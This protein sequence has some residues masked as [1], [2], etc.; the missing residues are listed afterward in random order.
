MHTPLAGT[1]MAQPGYRHP[2]LLPVAT[3][4]W[5]GLQRRPKK[6]GRS[7]N[8]KRGSRTDCSW[9]CSTINTT[10]CHALDGGLGTKAIPS[11][12]LCKGRSRQL[13]KAASVGSGR[14]RKWRVASLKRCSGHVPCDSWAFHEHLGVC[15]Q[16]ARGSPHT[17]LGLTQ[18]VIRR[19]V[20]ICSERH[21]GS[22]S[23]RPQ[24]YGGIG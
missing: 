3:K 7:H 20:L 2:N 16:I 5:S 6:I 19:I 18:L 22:G 13:R 17:S 23:P 14:Q 8:K 15:S 21:A 1:H 4:N 24:T 9:D 12:I 11:A 10:D